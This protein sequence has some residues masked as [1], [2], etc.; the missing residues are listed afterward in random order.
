M[1]GTSNHSVITFKILYMSPYVSKTR[2]LLAL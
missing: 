1:G 2:P